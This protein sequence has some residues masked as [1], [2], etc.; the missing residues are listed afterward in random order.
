MCLC[1][2]IPQSLFSSLR[3]QYST[4]TASLPCQGT[5]GGDSRNTK[6][7]LQSSRFSFCCLATIE[8]G[9]QPPGVSRLRVTSVAKHRLEPPRCCDRRNRISSCEAATAVTTCC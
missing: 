9:R 7:H 5:G 1:A 3:V 2:V 6:A 8:I 4:D